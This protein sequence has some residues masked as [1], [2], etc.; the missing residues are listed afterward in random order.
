MSRQ[1]VP[2]G[3]GITLL[4]VPTGREF[5]AVAA[6]VGAQGGLPAPW[7]VTPVGSGL[8]LVLSGIGKANA[9]GAAATALGRLSEPRSLLCLG[10]AGALP[11]S[12]ARVGDLI[13][14]SE[15]RFLDEGVETG[16]QFLS[17]EALGFPLGPEGGAVAADPALSSVLG[18]VAD[19]R[20]PVATISTC[21]GTDALARRRGELAIAEAMEGAAA[22]L[23][24]WRLGVPFAE[25]R[26][27]SNT[28]GARRAQV[29]DLDRALARLR[30]VA[31]RLASLLQ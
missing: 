9:A 25:L 22:G 29:W 10:V 7:E 21:A 23:V 19:H 30:D 20:G 13:L 3:H 28:T 5:E 2:S 16:E 14:A 12:P 8:A 24:A 18:R 11:G 4:L 17:C 15:S 31:E 1:T 6:G 26:V 27:I